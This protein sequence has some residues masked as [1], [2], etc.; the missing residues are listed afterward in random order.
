MKKQIIQVLEAV[1]EGGWSS[2]QISAMTSLSIASV[3]AYLGELARDGL[4]D[5]IERD[6]LHFSGRGRKSHLYGPRS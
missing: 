1:E 4:I 3:S 2:N 5:L 6:A